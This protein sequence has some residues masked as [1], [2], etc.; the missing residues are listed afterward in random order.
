MERAAQARHAGGLADRPPAELAG[1]AGMTARSTS[2]RSLRGVALKLAPVLQGLRHRH[3]I[4]ELEVAS[5]RDAH[6]DA[7]HSEA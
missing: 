6:G 5:D 1:V 2:F 7:S 3:L 4:G